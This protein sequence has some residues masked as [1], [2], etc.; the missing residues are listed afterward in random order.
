MAKKKKVTTKEVAVIPRSPYHPYTVAQIFKSEQ[1]AFVIQVGKD[2]FDEGGRLV[3]SKN[4][5][6]IYHSKIKENLLDLLDGGDADEIEEA[7]SA[8]ASLRIMPLR[9]N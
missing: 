2:L 4:A 5:A 1:D 3:F 9:I 7:M 8:L 6:D